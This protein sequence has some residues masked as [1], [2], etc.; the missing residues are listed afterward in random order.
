MTGLDKRIEIWETLNPPL[1]EDSHILIVLG[2]FI[3]SVSL[4]RHPPR[5]QVFMGAMTSEERDNDDSIIE[6]DAHFYFFVK[7]KKPHASF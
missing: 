6:D 7:H 5:G 3:V 4:F 1:Q 2:I